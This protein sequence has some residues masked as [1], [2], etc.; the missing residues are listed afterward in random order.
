MFALSHKCVERFEGGLEGTFSKVP[1]IASTASHR[2]LPHPLA[3]PRIPLRVGETEE[4][5]ETV[6]AVGEVEIGE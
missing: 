2:I 1:S 6:G 3:S 5:G 4:R